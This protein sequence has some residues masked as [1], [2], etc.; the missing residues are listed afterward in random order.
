MK[1]SLI[2][3]VLGSLAAIALASWV[4]RTGDGEGWWVFIITAPLA[5]FPV[6]FLVWRWLT[7]DGRKPSAGGVILAGVISGSIPHYLTF[8][9]AGHAG[10]PD[11]DEAP[12]GVG[13]AE[14]IVAHRPVR[15]DVIGAVDGRDLPGQ[16]DAGGD[17][18]SVGEGGR[19]VFRQRAEDGVAHVGELVHAGEQVAHAFAGELAEEAAEHWQAAQGAAEADDVARSGGAEG[20]AGEQALHVVDLGEL[21]ADLGAGD[22]R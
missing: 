8:L 4:Y 3:A 11:E 20:D 7:R 5:V 21:A 12:R 17:D 19:R 18:A 9:I 15:D 16:F 13:G 22:G 2:Y 14:R 6:A 1:N 10:Y